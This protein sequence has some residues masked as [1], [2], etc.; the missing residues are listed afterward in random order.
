MIN[1]L[2]TALTIM[3]FVSITSCSQAQSPQKSANDNPQTVERQA[4]YIDQKGDYFFIIFD[5][6]PRIRYLDTELDASFRQDKMRI[7]VSGEKLPIPPNVRMAGNPF[8]INTIEIDGGIAIET[9]MAAPTDLITAEGTVKKEGH[10]FII[11]TTE[12]IYVPKK[13]AENFQKEGASVAFTAK[14]LPY[15]PNVRMIGQPIE[16]VTIENKVKTMQLK[17]SM[18]TKTKVKIK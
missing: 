11:E 15:P 14:K 16:I 8:K 4:G 3:L 17:K 10:V 5:N 12:T 1:K 18:N 7:I 2:F 13:L 6:E 9:N